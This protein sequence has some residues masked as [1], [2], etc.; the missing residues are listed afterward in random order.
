[1]YLKQTHVV[2]GGGGKRGEGGGKRGEGGQ[3]G[4]RM[5]VACE[6]HTQVCLLVGSGGMLPQENAE[7]RSSQIASGTIWDKITIVNFKISGR[8]KFQPPP[9]HE[10]LIWYK[11]LDSGKAKILGYCQCHNMY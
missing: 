2:W 1:M 10:H 9:P 3:D 4:S 6:R 7:F 5:I 11:N 8:E